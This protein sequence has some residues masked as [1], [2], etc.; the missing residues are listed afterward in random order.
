[1]FV[2]LEVVG[3]FVAVIVQVV[4]GFV[5]FVVVAVLRIIVVDHCCDGCFSC[6]YY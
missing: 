2:V 6:C 5:V 4:C 1:M 3:F